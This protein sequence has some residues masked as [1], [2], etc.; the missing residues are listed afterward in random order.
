MFRAESISGVKSQD[1]LKSAYPKP[2][3]LPSVIFYD[4][5][6][7]LQSHLLTQKDH[8]FDHVLLP[9][10][11]FHF[12]SKHK[13]SDEFC[14]RECN[15]AKWKELSDDKGNWVFNSS[16]AE[17][18]NVWIG[19]YKSMV[20]NMVYHRNDFF[21]DEMIKRKN[22]IGVRRLWNQGQVPYHVPSVVG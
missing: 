22:E 12:K 14:Q 15:P 6:C 9:V 4:N 21:L 8:F 5:N 2:E 7:H 20:R 3:D 17:Q 18:V 10:D 1:F 13:Q 19:G 11:V 16:I